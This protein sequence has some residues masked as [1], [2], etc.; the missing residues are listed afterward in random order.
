MTEPDQSHQRV[1]V[2]LSERERAV[3]RNALAHYLDE[4]SEDDAAHDALQ[5]NLDSARERGIIAVG[6][7]MAD[8]YREVFRAYAQALEGAV[9]EDDEAAGEAMVEFFSGAFTSVVGKI[10]DATGQ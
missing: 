1:T 2:H 6:A 10:G 5:S 9:D 7:G 3:V 4:Q 8:T